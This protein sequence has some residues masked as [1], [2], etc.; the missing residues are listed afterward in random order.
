MH[1]A[2]QIHVID[3]N[4]L[5]SCKEQQLKVAKHLGSDKIWRDKPPRPP[6]SWL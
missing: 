3:Y 2:R 1:V 5:K 6:L 4:A